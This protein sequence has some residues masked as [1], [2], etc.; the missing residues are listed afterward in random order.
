[1]PVSAILSCFHVVASHAHR[2]LDDS[3][4]V[5]LLHELG[6]L[7]LNRPVLAMQDQLWEG[8]WHGPV[9]GQALPRPCVAMISCFRP[10][11]HQCCGIAARVQPY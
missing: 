9:T 8:H 2:Q 4:Q 7:M 11:G 1:M 10:G 3:P 5:W 6:E